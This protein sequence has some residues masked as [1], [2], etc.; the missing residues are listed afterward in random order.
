MRLI[1]WDFWR[2]HLAAVPRRL[3]AAVA[4]TAASIATLE[5]ISLG[6]L[7]LVLQQYLPRGA[8][9]PSRLEQFLAVL[10][11]AQD[12]AATAPLLFVVV[13]AALALKFMLWVAHSRLSAKVQSAVVL[14]VR[15]EA[16]MKLFLLT[17]TYIVR[18]SSSDMFYIIA[19]YTYQTGLSV[20]IVTS[21]APRV[22]GL[23]L[24]GTASMV[25]LPYM[26]LGAAAVLTLA[27]LISRL[28]H[29][30]LARATEAQTSVAEKFNHELN[31]AIH[32]LRTVQA[33]GLSQHIGQDLVR[34]T[35]ATNRETE[36]RFVIQNLNPMILETIS[37]LTMAILVGSVLLLAGSAE[38]RSTIAADGI[39]F[40][41]LLARMLPFAQIV[42]NSRLSLIGMQPT[43]NRVRD[44]VALTDQA[45]LPV[46][47]TRSPR[48]GLEIRLENVTVRY[49]GEARDALHG[50]NLRIPRGARVGIVGESGSGKSTLIALILGFVRPTTGRITIDGVDLHD[51]DLAAWRRQIGLV[52]QV[53]YLFDKPPIEVVRAGRPAVSVDKVGQVLEMVNARG[54][55]D[56]L[57]QG[58][59]T[60]LGEAS[61]TLSGGERQRLAIARAIAGDPALLVFDE[62]SSALDAE[63]EAT[64]IRAIEAV[65]P[66]RTVLTVAHRLKMVADYDMIVFLKDGAIVAAGEHEDLVRNVADYR[67]A[68]ELQQL[69]MA[70]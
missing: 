15:R 22:I 31:Q 48:F 57:P 8:G 63:N 60:P 26:T 35:D 32:G 39:L 12:S 30:E 18:R 28:F 70:S 7:A 37:H 69:S 53:P 40:V 27:I 50:A 68:L 23:A 45:L 33:Y 38:A 42:Q 46:G 16:I 66:G 11:L 13:V 14:S 54:F 5:L 19:A 67:R 17:P 61:G 36:R 55:V 62:A 24:L 51:C 4:L 9:P 41:V 10:G 25:A 47:G 34:L 21:T 6:G 20:N 3:W 65:S 52:D 1:D 59:N 58:L 56:R 43:I 49:P 44:M 29:R 64:V 2:P